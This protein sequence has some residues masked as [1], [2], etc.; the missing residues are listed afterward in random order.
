MVPFS[1][2]FVGE[3]CVTIYTHNRERLINKILRIE[4]VLNFI[5]V[6]FID[7]SMSKYRKW[8]TGSRPSSVQR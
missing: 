6:Y 4:S 7:Y 3:F 2:I 1:I 5:N 8:L